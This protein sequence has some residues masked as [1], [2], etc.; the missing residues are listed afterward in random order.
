MKRY[1]ETYRGWKILIMQHYSETY[2]GWKI[3]SYSHPTE[4][5]KFYPLKKKKEVM[6][7]SNIQQIKKQI[8][9]LQN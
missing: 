5:F 6:L 2:R 7:G 1:T 4:K 8:D 9:H 3:E